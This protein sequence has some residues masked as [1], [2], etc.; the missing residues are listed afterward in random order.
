[1]LPLF[2]VDVH[3]R[4]YF[5]NPV[6][7]RKRMTHQHVVSA[8]GVNMEVEAELVRLPLW[9][10]ERFF[11][12]VDLFLLARNRFIIPLL[13]PSLLLFDNPSIRSISRL[14]FSYWLLFCKARLL[15]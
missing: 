10:V 3:A 6:R 1:M 5:V 14:V 7:H 15:F 9:R 11:Q 12:P 13:V 4:K 2:D 8:D